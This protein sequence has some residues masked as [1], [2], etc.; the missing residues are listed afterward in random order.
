M[1]LGYK[2]INLNSIETDGKPGKLTEININKICKEYD[3]EFNTY[4]CFYVNELN[5]KQSRGNHSNINASEIL[6][7]VQGSFDI[8]LHN[9]TN[10]IKITLLQNKAIYINKNIWI[11]YCNFN[12]CV[13]MAFVSI[14]ASNKESCYDFNE[15][16]QLTT[17]NNDNVN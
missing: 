17:N 3:I 16:L 10:E 7:C 11:S 14:Y 8:I 5:S 9:G 13:I 2:L 6:I 15:Y 1:N 12:N 4:K